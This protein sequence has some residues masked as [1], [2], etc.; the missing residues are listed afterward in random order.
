M[1]KVTFIT[2]D[3]N[4]EEIE[5]AEGSLMEI[6]VKNGVDGIH[7]DCGGVCSCSTCHVKVH[8]DWL[9]KVGTATDIE[10]D[11][12]EDEPLADERSRLSCQIMMSGDLDG[13]IVE[14]VELL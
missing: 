10:R 1:A 8:P 12:F 9:G 5:N 6:A 14:V 11:L 7:G 2:A 13:L 4:T 3:G